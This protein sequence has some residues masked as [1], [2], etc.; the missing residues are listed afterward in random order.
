MDHRRSRSALTTTATTTQTTES[1][2]EST[3]ETTESTDETSDELI[4]P[5]SPDVAMAFVQQMADGAFQT[6][7]DSL[8]TGFQAEFPDAQS[9][10]TDFFETIGATTLAS[11]TVTRAYGHNG[12][13]DIVF[14]LE[15]DTGSAGVL[16]AVVEEEGVLKVFDYAGN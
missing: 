2:E 1:T 5:G 6:A 7:L 12:H 10:A 4:D 3:E 14:D 8:E 16:V 9:L 11:F 13:D 15:T